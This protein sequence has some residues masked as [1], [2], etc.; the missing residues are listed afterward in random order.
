[1]G[2]SLEW[3]ILLA[4]KDLP[5]ETAQDEEKRKTATIMEES[6]E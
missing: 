3:K 1:M 5:L 2:A 4:E 6:C